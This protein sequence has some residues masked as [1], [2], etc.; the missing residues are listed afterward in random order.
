MRKFAFL[1]SALVVISGRAFADPKCG[2]YSFEVTAN[3]PV[4]GLGQLVM[5]PTVLSG[6]VGSFEV[7]RFDD[8]DS[9]QKAGYNSVVFVVARK[10]DIGEQ[11]VGGY[12]WSSRPTR[13]SVSSY[14]SKENF[15]IA[16]RQS[17][18][19]VTCPAYS[20]A[21]DAKGH[22]TAEGTIVGSIR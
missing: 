13:V 18:S 4:K 6:S 11:P 1:L 19:S 15:E 5:P 10:G 3:M 16:F 9:P 22:V 21:I 2:K 20:L 17:S 8:E 7:F 14:S 12:L